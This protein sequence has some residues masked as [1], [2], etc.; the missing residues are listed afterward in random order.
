MSEFKVRRVEEYLISAE[1]V[2]NSLANSDAKEIA[3][4]LAY[5]Y[6][7]LSDETI[8]DIADR[9][10]KSSYHKGIRELKLLYCAL[11]Y[12]GELKG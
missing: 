10:T 9:M 5:F 11:Q 2:A 8:K 6:D 1:D 12:K 7:A 4:F 3:E